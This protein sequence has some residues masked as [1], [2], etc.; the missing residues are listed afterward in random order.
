[1]RNITFGV[2]DAH[3]L[4]KVMDHLNDELMTD[5]RFTDIERTRARWVF[6]DLNRFLDR[7]VGKNW[8]ELEVF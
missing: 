7:H 3:L 4:G 1:M 6:E 5:A 8:N 2:K